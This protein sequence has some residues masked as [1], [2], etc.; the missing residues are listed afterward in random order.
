[1]GFDI[2]RRY[3]VEARDNIPVRV[4]RK[5]DIA[6]S[7]SDVVQS[8]ERTVVG[9]DNRNPVPAVEIAH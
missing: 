9:V 6:H 2:A 3:N 5:E 4:E 7:C 8:S 1:M